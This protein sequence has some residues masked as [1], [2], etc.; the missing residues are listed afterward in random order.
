MNQRSGQSNKQQCSRQVGFV[1]D[2]LVGSSSVANSVVSSAPLTTSPSFVLTA[3]DLSQAF[4]WV[5]SD[6]LPQIL[7]A[8]QNQTSQF[9]ASNVTASGNMLSNT[10]LS[11]F[12]INSS[13]WFA[14]GLSTGNIVVPSFISTCCTLGNLS[15]SDP[16]LFG[17]QCFERS[18]SR[19]QPVLLSYVLYTHL[20]SLGC[21]FATQTFRRRPRIFTQPGEPGHKNKGRAF[22]QSG[23]PATRK[24]QGPGF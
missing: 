17:S 14:A 21:F 18:A 4:S 7:A 10:C 3:Q 8:V 5:L 12:P 11:S 13:P 23:G 22:R 19:H 15:L 20:G 1:W 16:S 9:M 6:S 24:C 2:F